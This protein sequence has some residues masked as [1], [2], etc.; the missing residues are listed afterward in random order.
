MTLTFGKMFQLNEYNA[1]IVMFTAL[2]T[3]TLMFVRQHFVCSKSVLT[4]YFSSGSPV[5]LTYLFCH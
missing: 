1:I 4:A 2:I 3:A 5:G